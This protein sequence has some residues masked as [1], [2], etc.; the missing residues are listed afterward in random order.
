MIY[1]QILYSK[2]KPVI[3]RFFSHKSL[4]EPES[5]FIRNQN[6]PSTNRHATSA[7]IRDARHRQ[8]N[9]R[10]VPPMQTLV[11]P[12]GGGGHTRVFPRSRGLCSG[13]AGR[14]KME[15]PALQVCVYV[16]AR[17]AGGFE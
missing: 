14:R 10:H 5:W 8:L 15:L 6:C 11:H 1:E 16:P 4:K 13:G 2:K 7:P 9:S 17:A 3:S 12:Y